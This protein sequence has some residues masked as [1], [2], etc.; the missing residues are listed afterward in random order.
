[1]VGW[2][3]GVAPLTYRPSIGDFGDRVPLGESGSKL[4]PLPHV[5]AT[6]GR[7]VKL[8]L[9]SLPPG[10]SPTKSRPPDVPIDSLTSKRCGARLYVATSTDP[11]YGKRNHVLNLLMPHLQVL[12]SY[13]P[14]QLPRSQWSS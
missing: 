2:W 1:M 3:S 5:V 4:L 11:L 14:Q 9:R 10:G 7:V 12:L 6:P 13:I 8:N